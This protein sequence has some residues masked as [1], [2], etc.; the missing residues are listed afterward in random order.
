MIN[1]SRAR[2]TGNKRED[3]VYRHY[4]GH[5]DGLHERTFEKLLEDN[6]AHL[7]TLAVRRMLPKNR[8]GKDM[9]RRLKVYPGADHPH[10]AQN[11]TP[12]EI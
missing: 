5:T 8:L 1:A 7:V 2:V 4:T 3:K 12:L 9:L 11:P 6:P 10:V